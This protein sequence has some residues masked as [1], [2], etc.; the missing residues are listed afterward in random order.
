MTITPE[1]PEDA[2]HLADLNTPPGPPGSGR[3]RYAAATHFY[4]RGMISAEALEAY[5]ILSMI[6]GEDPAALVARMSGTSG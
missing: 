2:A 6:D 3:V 1:T 4:N 5:R